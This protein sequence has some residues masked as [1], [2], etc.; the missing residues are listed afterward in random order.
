MTKKMTRETR[1]FIN[2]PVRVTPF[3]IKNE[4]KPTTTKTTNKQT[5]TKQKQKLTNSGVED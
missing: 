4:K 5:K 3:K 1:N 2:R